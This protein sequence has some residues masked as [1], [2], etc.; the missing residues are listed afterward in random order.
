MQRSAGAGPENKRI[1]NVI[2]VHDLGPSEGG[3]DVD[4]FVGGF[5]VVVGPDESVPDED[6]GREGEAGEEGAGVGEGERADRGN[7]LGSDGRVVVE[8]SFE[9]ERVELEEVEEGSGAPEEGGEAARGW[10]R[11]DHGILPHATTTS[12]RLT[13][14]FCIVQISFKVFKN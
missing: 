8:G 5:G 3:E 4:G 10:G 9:E 1:G 7:E 14:L 13:H 12:M 2:G 11:E 6:R